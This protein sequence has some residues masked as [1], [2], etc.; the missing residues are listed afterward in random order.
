MEY[1]SNQNIRYDHSKRAL[2][3]L[4]DRGYLGEP[5]LASIEMR[6]IPHWEPWQLAYTYL[7]LLKRL[8]MNPSKNIGL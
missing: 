6:A 1:P 2:K 3:T 5:V 8:A 4:L 7:T